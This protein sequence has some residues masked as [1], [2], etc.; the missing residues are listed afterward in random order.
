[1][2]FPFPPLFSN[3]QHTKRRAVKHR[4]R[5][6]LRYESLEERRL[7]A[8]DTW[9]VS[10]DDAGRTEVASDFEGNA[11]V[12]KLANSQIQLRKFSSDGQEIWNVNLG[13]ENNGTLTGGVRALEVDS[14]GQII[15]AGS[16]E[17]TL[18]FDP[19]TSETILATDGIDGYIASFQDN[20]SSASLNWA[21]LVGDGVKDIAL[22]D[23]SNIYAVGSFG[24]SLE[25][26][27]TQLF[28]S[29]TNFSVGTFLSQVSSDGSLTWARQIED[30]GVFRASSIALDSGDTIY[31]GGQNYTDN[32]SVQ[33]PQY[34]RRDD[35]RTAAC[36][37]WWH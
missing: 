31:I 3:N 25:Y 22:D 37:W 17:G 16:Y 33:N 13:V 12:A 35:R 9:Q 32:P 6:T 20:G 29:A 2:K 34:P 21:H 23:S 19:S 15:I 24:T 11:I 18:D 36:E 5:H 27:S 14:S 30:T 7:L 1:M 4:F 8:G 28:P 26:D 10:I